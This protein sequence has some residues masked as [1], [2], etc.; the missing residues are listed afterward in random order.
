[1]RREFD[2]GLPYHIALEIRLSAKMIV[3]GTGDRVRI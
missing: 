2:I 1:M 3:E